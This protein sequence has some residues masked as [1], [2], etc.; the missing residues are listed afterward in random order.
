M[1]E[2]SELFT[3]IPKGRLGG[4]KPVVTMRAVLNNKKAKNGGS[5]QA[6]FNVSTN[7]A[8]LIGNPEWVALQI[9]HDAAA[10]LIRIAPL[11]ADADGG[12]KFAH[13]TKKDSDVRT[14][15]V[16]CPAH[17][18][19]IQD[20]MASRVKVPHKIAEGALI[21]DMRPILQ[22]I[23]EGDMVSVQVGADDDDGSDEAG[24]APATAPELVDGAEA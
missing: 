3:D 24:E 7:L 19:D 23:K 13:K 11:N 14:Y 2:L 16:S 18:I 4:G 20:A 9:G 8:G 6:V 22:A 1:P 21:L 5:V 10:G 17:R 15:S 12:Y